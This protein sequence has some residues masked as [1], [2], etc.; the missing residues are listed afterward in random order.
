[1][2]ED[3]GGEEKKIVIKGCEE[4]VGEK[5]GD[6]ESRDKRISRRGEGVECAYLS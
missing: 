5:V 3:I 4:K 6:R 1:V 2:R